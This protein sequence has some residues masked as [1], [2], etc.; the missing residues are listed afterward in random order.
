MTKEK[1][2]YKI[3]GVSK[4]ASKE[5]IKTAYKNLAKK[6]HPD[7]NKDKDVSEKFKEINEAASVLGDDQK[8]RS[9]TSTALQESNSRRRGRRIFRI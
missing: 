8:K 5:E 1:D 6:Y 9:M 4:N 2:Y 3:L 7:I